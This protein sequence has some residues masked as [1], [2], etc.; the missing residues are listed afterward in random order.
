MGVRCGNVF[1]SFFFATFKDLEKI[2]YKIE[3]P[4]T[5]SLTVTAVKT[6]Y[7]CGTR[8]HMNTQYPQYRPPQSEKVVEKG[9]TVEMKIAKDTDSME[10]AG[11]REEG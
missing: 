7:V 5:S 8:V 11:D 2:P 10:Y 6:G 1:F 4:D 3:I 9:E